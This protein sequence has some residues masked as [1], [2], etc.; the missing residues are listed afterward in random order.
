ML[1]VEG[2]LLTVNVGSKETAVESIDG[3]LESFIGGRGVAT[4]LAHDRI[5]FDVD[6]F[7]TENSLFF[8]TG[9]MQT[10]NMSFTGRMNCTGL[11]P[12]TYFARGTRALVYA[13]A[14]GIAPDAGLAVLNLAILSVLA[15]V[16]FVAG[17]RS[18]PRTD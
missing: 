3:V 16:L 6:P 17:A 15:V 10:S 11:S 1:H 12:L 7:G 18:V 13:P 5:P 2:P 9:P 4:R 8:T 14:D